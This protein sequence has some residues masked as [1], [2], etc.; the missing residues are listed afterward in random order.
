MLPSCNQLLLQHLVCVLCNLA[1]HS[2]ECKMNSSS[3]AICIGQSLLW[4]G[5]SV[6][7]QKEDAQNANVLVQQM[8]DSAEDIFGPGCLTLLRNAAVIKRPTQMVLRGVSADSDSR[9]SSGSSYS[10]SYGTNVHCSDCE[11]D[12]FLLLSIFFY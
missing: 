11:N 7:V 8:I 2:E 3:L 5:N 6:V 9:Q 1:I 12:P 4:P 10:L